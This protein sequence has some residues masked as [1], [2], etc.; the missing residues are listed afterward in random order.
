MQGVIT[1]LLQ[2]YFHRGVFRTLIGEKQWS[3]F[4]SR[5]DKNVDATLR[6]L[7]E[8]DTKATFF[9][10]GWIGEKF[11]ALIKR[12]AEEGHEIAS[13]GYLARA[14]GEMSPEQFRQDI[15]RARVSLQ[16]AS[17]RKVIGYRCA[18]RYIRPREKW[19]LSVLH[20][21]GYVYDA[22]CCPP[23]AGRD[24]FRLQKGARQIKVHDG[25]IHEFPISTKSLLGLNLPISGGNYIR[26]LPHN[27]MLAFFEDWLR[28][29]ESPFVLYFHPWELDEEQPLISAIGPISRMK[30][31]RN[32][33]K[34]RTMLPEYFRRARFIP[35]RDY[36]G[37]EPE[38]VECDALDP[39][40]NTK[41]PTVSRGFPLRRRPRVP[42]SVVIPS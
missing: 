25:S 39:S 1:V 33:G 12:L 19:A 37:I 32:L 18:Y 15:R 13:A 28:G 27:L 4:H 7:D 24:F 6:L 3:R 38:R 14:V 9:T 31:Y 16:S 30:Q 34:L 17:G 26:Q 20:E 41:M 35:I 29:R 40:Y 8:F 2:D 36:L 22:S 10:L 11:P 42:V 23:I 21:E 5:L